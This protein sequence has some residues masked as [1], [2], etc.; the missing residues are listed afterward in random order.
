MI[1]VERLDALDVAI[2][3]DEVLRG[4][5]ARK[6]NGRQLACLLGHISPEAA[7]AKDAS[8]CPAETLDPWLAHLLPYIDDACSRRRRYE[9]LRRTAAVLRRW[10]QLPAGVRRRLD[11]ECRAIAVRESRLVSAA[12]RVINQMLTAMEREC[13]K[14]T[15]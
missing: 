8:A 6:R 13:A 14:V 9:F 4:A 7:A 11:Y 1:P 2:K 10:H 3:R 15:T 12:D 5:W